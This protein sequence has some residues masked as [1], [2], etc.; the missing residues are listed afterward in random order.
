MHM[1]AGFL[2]VVFVAGTASASATVVERLDCVPRFPV[3]CSNLHVACSGRSK[4]PTP[5]FSIAF[6]SSDAEVNFKNGNRWATGVKM[7]GDEK[8]LLAPDGPDWIRIDSK[9]QFSH[10]IYHNGRAL[11]SVGEC[12]PMVSD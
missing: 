5:R 7:N 3:F 9:N 2:I 12:R 8:V 4:V 11:M 10:R 6:R 1:L